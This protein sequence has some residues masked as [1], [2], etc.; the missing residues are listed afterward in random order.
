MEKITE[1]KNQQDQGRAIADNTAQRKEIGDATPAFIDNRPG[2]AL[3]L[4]MAEMMNNSPQAKQAV[5]F[6]A[7]ADNHAAQR[8][9]IQ[10]KENNT[11]LPD[12]LKTGM[13]N[14]SG[15]SMDDV[16]VHRNSDKPAQLNAHAY[17]QGTDIHLASGQEKHLP[18]ELGHVVQQKQGRVKPTLQMKGEV[19]INDDAFLEKEA[20]VMGSKALQ[21]KTDRNSQAKSSNRIMST[22]Q[23]SPIQ[24]RILIKGELIEENYEKKKMN[25]P[26]TIRKDWL[27]DQ[28]AR[29]YKSKLEFFLHA[30]GHPVQVGLQKS[31]G[32]WYRLPLPSFIK[33]LSPKFFLLG[34]LHNIFPVRKLVKESNQ[35]T[36]HVVTESGASFKK[37][38]YKDREKI[39]SKEKNPNAHLVELGLAKA[40]FAFANKFAPKKEDR[41]GIRTARHVN[42]HEIGTP[43]ITVEKPT[44]EREWGGGTVDAWEEGASKHGPL[45]RR[46][47]G[48]SY[49]MLTSKDD[50]TAFI[51]PNV[52]EASSYSMK[53]ATGNFLA[54]PEIMEALNDDIA[55]I[56]ER[57][58]KKDLKKND[59]GYA[60]EYNKV[61]QALRA[62]SLRNLNAVYPGMEAVIRDNAQTKNGGQSTIPTDIELAMN[63]RNTAMM[64]AIKMAFKQGGY[65]LASLGNQHVL[66]L[67]EFLLK[68]GALPFPIITYSDFINECSVNAI[69]GKRVIPDYEKETQSVDEE[70][71]KAKSKKQ[72]SGPLQNPWL[73]PPP[74]DPLL[75]KF[76]LVSKMTSPEA[77]VLKW[78][79]A[80]KLIQKYGSNTEALRLGLEGESTLDLIG[81]RTSY[82]TDL[83]LMLG[84]E[85]RVDENIQRKV[86]E[87]I[88]EI[89]KNRNVNRAPNII[90]PSINRDV[91]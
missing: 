75:V 23:Q 83:D 6:Q 27:N 3:Q 59:D 25:V 35:K 28:Y 36:A 74:P 65:A 32:I 60:E 44:R 30:K 11:G 69:M 43:D 19:N 26:E 48:R 24:R 82:Q 78:R 55:G 52:S 17:A 5:Q 84:Y 20:D 56:Y 66:D 86:I 21:M 70:Q 77:K 37:E 8:Q 81:L 40:L 54:K 90:E 53:K 14:L 12:N 73:N 33:L 49:F 38:A 79:L 4:R 76:L 63:H 29:N 31:L 57:I 46:P 34:E 62:A 16:K 58:V 68:N 71:P 89:I 64:E 1:N 42:R 80:D 2:A 39:D 67:K 51:R 50:T 72:I 15:M 22:S 85:G 45:Y 9:P 13:E 61:F 10:K 88:A 87:I 91:Y 7:M 41:S 18:H 47:D